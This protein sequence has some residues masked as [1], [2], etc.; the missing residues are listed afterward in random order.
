MVSVHADI[1]ELRS[2]KFNLPLKSSDN[3]VVFRG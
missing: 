3:L 2:K 1:I